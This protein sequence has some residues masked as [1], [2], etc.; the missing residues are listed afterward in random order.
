MPESADVGRGSSNGPGAGF[1]WRSGSGKYWVGGIT[2]EK[3]DSVE[4]ESG[5]YR[6]G[7]GIQFKPG[8]G[9]K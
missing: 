4:V 3:R 1:S 8:R 2:D 5:K 7:N 9:N 6:T